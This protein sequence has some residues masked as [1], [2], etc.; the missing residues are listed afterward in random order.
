[1]AQLDLALGD[2]TGNTEK[3]ISVAKEAR[4]NLKAD[5]VLYPELAITGYPPEDLLYRPELHQRVR[6]ALTRIRQEVSGI[7]LVVGHP[8]KTE[9]GLYNSASVIHDGNIIATYSKFHLPNYSVFDEKRYFIPDGSPVVVNIKNVPVG[10]VICEDLWQPGPLKTTIGAGA[11][12]VLSL[13]A[14]PFNRMKSEQRKD[15]LVQKQKEEGR[16]PIV[17]VNCV[18]GQDELVFDGGSLVLDANSAITHLAPRY[19]EAIIPVEIEVNFAPQVIPGFI[20]PPM[21]EDAV[22]YNALVLGTRDYIQKNG[23][24]HCLIGLSG[25]IDSALTLAIAVD[26]IGKDNVRAVFMPSRFT[27]AMSGEDSKLIANNLGVK[28]TEIP[29]EPVF[30][31]FLTTLAPILGEKKPDLTEENIQARI[32]GTLLMALSNAEGGIVLTTGNKS[33]MAVGYA[34]LYGDMAGGFAVL[35]DVEKTAVFRLAHYRNSI[36]DDIPQR[37]ITRPPSAELSENQK[38]ED[39]LPPYGILDQ[40]ISLYVER[41]QS[42]EKIIAAGFDS[43]VVKRVIGLIDHNEYKRRQAPPGIRVSQRAFGRDWRYPITSGYGRDQKK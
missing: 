2:I 24:T 43:H 14:S 25:G 34:T 7:Y 20:A 41:D 37:I 1:M 40:I 23:F 27:A 32:R 28:F 33:E 16:V 31:T 19:Q 15:N 35:K 3:I 38:D 6:D 26:A 9:R 17:Y 39:T 18:G 11:K 8:T 30:Q 22:I 42:A 21:T 36:S 13:N 12:I 5:V 10:I 4:D 29:I